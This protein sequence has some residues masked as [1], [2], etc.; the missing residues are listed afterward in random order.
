LT[1]WIQKGAHLPWAC[2]TCWWREHPRP[3]WACNSKRRARW[4]TLKWSWE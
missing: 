3:R 2:K 1:G 4:S